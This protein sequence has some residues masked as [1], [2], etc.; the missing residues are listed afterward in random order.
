MYRAIFLLVPLILV[1]C[2]VN[3]PAQ[4]ES[5]TDTTNRT[6]AVLGRCPPDQEGL[7]AAL[8]SSAIT[9]GVNRI[10]SALKAAGAEDTQTVLVNRAVN[11]RRPREGAEALCLTVARG[12]FFSDFAS[13]ENRILGDYYQTLGEL[14]QP[15]GD[16]FP[17]DQRG[18][19]LKRWFED[20]LPLARTPEFFFLGE[21]RCVQGTEC[22]FATLV[23]REAY[24]REP[25][26][27]DTWRHRHRE[28]LIALALTD[29][30]APA[31][32]S[33]GQGATIKLGTLEIGESKS[34]EENEMPDAHICLQRP[35]ADDKPDLVMLSPDR[36]EAFPFVPT[37][38]VQNRR[39]QVLVSETR[40]EDAFL[41]FMAEVFGSTSD[42]IKDE[43]GTAFIPSIAA[44]NAE[45]EKQAEEKALNAYDKT[46]IEAR[47]AL[48][49]C[50]ASGTADDAAAARIASRTF[51][52]SARAMN[53][54]DS[55]V[56]SVYPP[57]SPVDVVKSACQE[58]LEQLQ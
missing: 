54:N 6:L 30:N 52:Q 16:G 26:G 28:V 55:D 7:F 2:A 21:V 47:N 40:E 49:A 5:R 4:S 19:V 36:S 38:G 37:S 56:V 33:K 18:D 45:Q 27:K 13:S 9:V 29:L 23:P 10:G 51:N 22:A 34:F 44:E 41:T 8:L 58:A 3:P 35:C 25:L 32:L 43:L 17:Y 1:G 39:L 57:N 14:Y 15:L 31:D 12:E 48:Q 11:I 53:H 46:R 50:V 42:E 20:G 24:L